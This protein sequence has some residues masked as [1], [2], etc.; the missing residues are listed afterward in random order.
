MRFLEYETWRLKKD[1]D[2]EA[3]DKII[4]DWFAFVVKNRQELF[5]EWVSAKYYRKTDRDGNPNGLFVMMF[6]YESL[7]GHHAYK[8]RRKDWD[9]P[10]EAYKAVDPY[11]EFFEL[12]SVTTEYLQP[13]EV[14]SW[15][16]F[17]K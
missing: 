5:P 7:E 9:G 1:I 3:Y 15:F 16:D 11:Q 2:M 6:E 4:K 17:S 13:Q 10:Y 12:E 14:E 8:E